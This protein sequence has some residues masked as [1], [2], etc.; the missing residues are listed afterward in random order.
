[1]PAPIEIIGFFLYFYLEVIGED[2]D[3]CPR[4]HAISHKDFGEGRGEGEGNILYFMIKGSF[5]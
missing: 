5:I 4:L 3:I 1:M 2:S